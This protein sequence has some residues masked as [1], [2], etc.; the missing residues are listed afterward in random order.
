MSKIAISRGSAL[1]ATDI[2]P[3]APRDLNSRRN[4]YRALLRLQHKEKYTLLKSFKSILK[5]EN[6]NN[7]A[8]KKIIFRSLS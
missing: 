2:R 6:L 1:P 4:K 3:I 5:S 7:S 8:A